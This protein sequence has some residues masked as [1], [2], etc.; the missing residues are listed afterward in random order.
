MGPRASAGA[1]QSQCGV[2]DRPADARGLGGLEPAPGVAGV[3]CE[4]AA[5]AIR[6]EPAGSLVTMASRGGREYLMTDAEL[7]PTALIGPP[8]GNHAASF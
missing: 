6:A 8:S 5:L 4:D 1:G 7:R 3:D 2:G